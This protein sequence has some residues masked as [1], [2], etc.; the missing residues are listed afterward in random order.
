MY[1]CIQTYIT[2]E[3]SVLLTVYD[4][5]QKTYTGLHKELRVGL[6]VMESLRLPMKKPSVCTKYL[7]CNMLQI[8]TQYTNV[9][10]STG[11]VGGRFGD[12]ESA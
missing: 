9:C 1:E 8:H 4:L 7:R 2:P 12:I 6:T 10:H 3:T 11:H 5:I